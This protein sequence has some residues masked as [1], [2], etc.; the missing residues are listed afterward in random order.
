[1][2]ILLFVNSFLPAVGGKEIVVHYLAK[3]LQKLGNRVRIIGPTGW[4]KNRKQ[5]FEYPVHRWPTL[6]GLYRDAVGYTQLLL[7]VALWG[8][9]VVHAHTTYPNGYIASLL[10]KKCNLPLVITPHGHDIHVIPELGFGHRLDPVK[11]KKIE[12]AIQ[13]AEVVTAIS[14]SV[15]SS[16]IDAGC[17]KNKIRKIPNGIDIERFQLK[18]TQNSRRWLGLPDESKLILSVGNF[19][20]RKGQDIL[21]AAMPRILSKIPHARLVIVGGKQDALAAKVGASGLD[22][23]V[24]L[25]GSIPFPFSTTLDKQKNP[26]SSNDH[27]ADLYCQSDVYVSASINKEAEGL[28][29]A[30]LDAM[31]A[32]LPVV[33][34]QI[35]GSRDIVINKKTGLLVPPADHQQLAE[36]IITVLH[37]QNRSHEMGQQGRAIAQRYHWNKIARRYV[38]VYQEAAEKS[39]KLS[40]YSP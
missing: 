36:A 37:H 38:S 18:R 33:A 24:R 31:A 15:E 12:Y 35:S 32:G 7:D 5:K 11:C 6:R 2:K 17:D 10:K 1:M 39:G 28:S 30:I 21:L 4:I 22:E 26:V 40:K 23:Y 9:D 19:H 34:T 29:L 25:T 13:S 16:L 20:P 27:L 3:E 8:C 14:D